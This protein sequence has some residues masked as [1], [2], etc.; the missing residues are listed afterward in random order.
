M[1]VSGGKDSLALWDVLVELGYRTTGLYVAQGIGEYSSGS[2][3]KVEAFARARDL[4]LRIVD[5]AAEGGGLA[6]PEVAVVDPAVALLRVRHAE[7]SLLRRR[8]RSP[9]SSTCSPPGTTWTTRPRGCS[10][11]SCTGSSITWRVSVR[12]WSRRIPGSSAR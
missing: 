3:Q 8:P 4:P 6:V 1:A 5:L 9:A 10:A 2:Q 7:A 12:S 11:T